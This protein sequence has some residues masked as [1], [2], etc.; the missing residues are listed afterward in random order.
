MIVVFS[1]YIFRKISGPTRRSTKG[2]W[3]NEEDA[4]LSRAVKQFD[5]RN[6]KRI[7]EA[8]PG[9]T[10]IQ[11]LHRWQKVLNPELVKG[12]WTKEE[13]E[14][15]IKL[16]A[17]H[18]CKRWSI[19]A[20]SLPGRI[21][22]QCRER[23]YN[24][25]NPAIKK[26]A[27]TAEEEVTLIYSHQKYGNKWAEIAKHLHGRAEN[28]IKNHWNCSLKK[29]LASYLSSKS[30]DQ[31]SGVIALNLEDCIPKV[32]CIEAD[33]SEQGILGIGSRQNPS[34]GALDASLRPLLGDESRCFRVNNQSM[35]LEDSR[36]LD[37]EMKVISARCKHM[38]EVN[39]S[40]RHL[41][42]SIDESPGATAQTAMSCSSCVR[43]CHES[44][45]W[46]IDGSAR[47]N[48]SDLQN[49]PTIQPKTYPSSSNHFCS[50]DH[51]YT[52]KTNIPGSGFSNSDGGCQS[53]LVP[54]TYHLHMHVKDV[55]VST[56]S[57]ERAI[58]NSHIRQNHSTGE[59]STP[60][61]H[62]QSPASVPV[63]PASFL[64]SAAK[65]FNNTPSILRKRKHESSK[66]LFVDCFNKK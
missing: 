49:C 58:S 26:D 16:V 42:F 60:P 57:E 4:I 31:P 35:T 11:C 8:F 55:M 28:S 65:S 24:H 7:A 30:F 17:K 15:I 9:R 36:F 38:T 20:K 22:K 12:S 5:G 46:H 32:G 66:Q 63:S 61:S 62:P 50:D 53:D 13:D 29:K 56:S 54:G 43:S 3:T 33:S 51:S 64:R 40:T 39:N 34:K 10:D 37:I 41:N 47:G 27:W 59:C 45:T 25:L 48:A 23:W 6:W 19:I 44:D 18:G 2:G 21:G 1:P 14:C 52:D